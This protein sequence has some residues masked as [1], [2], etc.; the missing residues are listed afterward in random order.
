[1]ILPENCFIMLLSE[2]VG[3]IHLIKGFLSILCSFAV[4]PAIVVLSS[5]AQIGSNNSTAAST[6]QI[7]YSAGKTS[8]SKGV[9]IS[10]DPME[11]LSS[12]TVNLSLFKDV[13][14]KAVVWKEKGGGLVMEKLSNGSAMSDPCWKVTGTGS[15][16]GMGLKVNT[17]SGIADMSDYEMG[18]LRFKYRGKRGAFLVGVRS[19]GQPDD[20]IIWA[21]I[22]VT[23]AP[24]PDQWYK[25]VIPIREFLKE[26]SALD[27]K[28][29]EQLFMLASVKENGYQV[30]DS[31]LLDDISWSKK[32]DWND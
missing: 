17:P 24:Q 29:V 11:K 1:M 13:I 6:N 26:P 22:D 7:V 12:G 4:V 5:C 31:Y 16:M 32:S 8:G 23:N 14:S 18:T 2:W 21:W 27:L 15:W 28:K 3:D 20:K 10:A 9:I 30:G 25:V 19:A